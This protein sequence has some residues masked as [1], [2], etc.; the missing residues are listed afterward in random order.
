MLISF[1][2]HTHTTGFQYQHDQYFQHRPCD[3]IAHCCSWHN[4]GRDTWETAS[5]LFNLTIVPWKMTCG[6]GPLLCMAEI[7]VPFGNQQWDN[8]WSRR[9]C[10]SG[11]LLRMAWI[12]VPFGNWQWDN[13]WCERTCGSGPL[14]CMAE[15]SKH[16]CN[17]NDNMT[18]QIWKFLISSINII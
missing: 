1:C 2:S 18:W 14:L 9:I 6:S 3:A 15:F 5:P 4:S 17:I 7:L 10:G 12:L 13:Y 11:P 16:Q 8:Y